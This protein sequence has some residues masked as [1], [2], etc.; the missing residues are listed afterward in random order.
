MDTS[1]KEEC[2][3][4]F[5]DVHVPPGCC[6]Q[7]HMLPKDLKQTNDIGKLRIMFE[8]VIRRFKTLNLI[9]KELPV[10]LVVNN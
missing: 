9:A 1:F 8:Q 5:I 10:S 4:H 6:G 2:A 3:G 7:S